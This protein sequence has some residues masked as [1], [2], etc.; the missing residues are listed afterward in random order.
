MTETPE[1]A[2]IHRQIQEIEPWLVKLEHM[3]E[4]DDP[5]I[6]PEVRRIIAGASHILE[7]LGT[8]WDPVMVFAVLAFCGEKAAASSETW[9]AYT[10]DVAPI[11]NGRAQGKVVVA[12]HGQSTSEGFLSRLR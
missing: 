12:H 5:R 2:Q 7:A 6:S 4:V 1:A 10:Q 8:G 9:D 11:V 3:L